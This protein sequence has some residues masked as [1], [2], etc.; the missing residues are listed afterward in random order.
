MP[1]STNGYSA[2]PATWPCDDT[3]T[4]GVNPLDAVSVAGTTS[5]RFAV[6]FADA[7]SDGLLDAHVTADTGT[8]L[9]VN[10][11]PSGERRSDV[12]PTCEL[13]PAG[14]WSLITIGVSTHGCAECAI[15]KYGEI[16]GATSEDIA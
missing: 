3:G 6:A 1:C 2:S 13:C 10:A 7:N 8:D 5:S 11:C 15:G 4:L 14:R 16:S 12:G 9:Y